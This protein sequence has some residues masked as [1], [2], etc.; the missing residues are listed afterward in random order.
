[1]FGTELWIDDVNS[2]ARNPNFG[3]EKAV[4]GVLKCMKERSGRDIGSCFLFR[5]MEEK[6]V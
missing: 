2:C 1:M 6:I 3:L 5:F 4:T